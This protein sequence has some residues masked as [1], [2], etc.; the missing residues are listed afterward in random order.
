LGRLVLGTQRASC[1]VLRVGRTVVGSAADRILAS[2]RTRP[3]H[4]GAPSSR[5]L[6][7]LGCGVRIGLVVVVLL[8]VLA[9]IPLAE[10]NRPDVT[11]ADPALPYLAPAGTHGIIPRIN[12]LTG[13][14]QG[15]MPVARP[16]VIREGG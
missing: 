6:G 15:E 9:V 11:G 1:P 12:R 4:R 5:S 7:R 3:V 8:P 16:A 13:R 14:Q 10:L 2:P